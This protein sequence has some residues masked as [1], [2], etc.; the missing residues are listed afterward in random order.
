MGSLKE[1]VSN[2]LFHGGLMA[3]APFTGGLSMAAGAGLTAAKAG[4]ALQSGKGKAGGIS[5]AE[6]EAERRRQA[7]LAA[8]SKGRRGTLLAGGTPGGPQPA[9]N[10]VTLLGGA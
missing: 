10:R 5:T 6:A 3:L 7:A 4:G 2:D 1:I 8:Q 9:T